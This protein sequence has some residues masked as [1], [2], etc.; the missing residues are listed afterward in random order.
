MSI[1]HEQVK[2]LLYQQ[3][4]WLS[5]FF[6]PVQQWLF[7]PLNDWSFMNISFWALHEQ[8]QL[9]RVSFQSFKNSS[10]ALFSNMRSFPVHE[11]PQIRWRTISLIYNLTKFGCIVMLQFWW[12]SHAHVQLCHHNVFWS[13][14]KLHSL[15][16]FYSKQSNS[17]GKGP[18]SKLNINRTIFI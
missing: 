5:V 7:L 17:S 3:N 15:G 14:Y 9:P 2:N 8:N 18:C 16:I 13:C 6:L 12:C 4:H 1:F 10:M 11:H